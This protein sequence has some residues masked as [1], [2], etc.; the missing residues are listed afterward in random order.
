MTKIISDAELQKHIDSSDA[1]QLKEKGNEYFNSGCYDEALACYTK[2]IQLSTAEDSSKAVFLK[3]R[4]AAYLKLEQYQNAVNDCKAAL[5]INPNDTK[6][7]FR[8]CQALET[9]ERFD[10]AY[11]DAKQVHNLDPKNSAIQP[12]LTRLNI[13]VQELIKL[14]STTSNKIDQMFQFVFGDNPDKEKRLQAVNNMI[15]LVREKNSADLMFQR[16]I[17]PKIMG[18]MKAEKNPEMITACVRIFGELCKNNVDRTLEIVRQVSI[19]Q[20]VEALNSKVEEQVNAAQ[21]SIQTVLNTLSGMDLNA[22]KKPD[23]GMI[24]DNAVELDAFMKVIAYNVNSRAMSALGRDALIEL[25][26]KN[27]DYTTLN[28]CEK[29]LETDGI[30]R[31]LEVASEMKEYKYESCMDITDNTRTLTAVAFERMYNSLGADALR[32]TFRNKV[33]VFVKEQLRGEEIEPKVRI[34]AAFTSLLQG[35]L[36]VGNYCIAQQGILEM[37]IVM[38]GSDDQIQQ[39]VAAEA[40]IAA[41]SKKDKCTTIVSHGTNILKKLF[42]SKSDN[43]RVRALVGLCKLSSLGG[44]DSSIRPFAD[45]SS[46][47]LSEACRRFLISPAKDRDIRKWAAEGLSYLTLDAD[48]KEELIEDKTAILALIE[49]A[50]TGDL[51]V[52]YGVITTLVN[53]TNCYDVQEIIPEM[54]KLAEFAKQHVP[55]E[56]PL[57]DPDFVH[58][59]TKLLVEMGV[60]S[61]LVALSKTESHNSRELIARVFNTICEHKEL[62]GLVVQ[63]G[64]GKALVPMSLEGTKNGKLVAAQ[65]LSRLAVTINPEVAFPGQRCVE[66]VRP[67]LQLLHPDCTGLQ[68]F[69]ALMALCNLAYVSPTV[70]NRIAKENGISWIENYIYEDHEMIK[71]AAMQCMV[72]LLTQEEVL[73][74]YEGKNDRVKYWTLMCNDEDLD[75]AKAACSGLAMITGISKKCCKR[76]FEAASWLEV[77]HRVLVNEENEIQHRGAC[78][79]H[80]MMSCSKS[81]AE[82]LIE[83]DIMEILMALSLTDDPKCA[84][85]R[86]LAKDSLKAAEEWKLIKPAADQDSDVE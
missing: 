3:N 9:L 73:K 40:L 23:Q 29:L 26:M 86:D 13:K 79:V 18:L 2:A 11:K 54:I 63:Q 71:R 83:T 59:R 24:K 16:G 50:K 20:M 12:I 52:L 14:H 48:I 44:T 39:M 33:D 72:N 67:I 62:R 34:T 45:G 49:L 58:K 28:W 55:E 75:T 47:K 69:E 10:E 66:V 61:A 5:E 4:A 7:L 78:I 60:T 35:A 68:N 82:K 41:A 77:L 57:D 17:I 15:V 36:D 76:V 1:L 6:A 21:C 64:G 81:V 42:Q 8:R 46:S 74:L 43:I 25:L 85:A 65:A 84:K 53:L 80:N 31:L 27:S 22:S 56:H 51:S 70:R 30:Q 19:P 37:M 38:A 32:E